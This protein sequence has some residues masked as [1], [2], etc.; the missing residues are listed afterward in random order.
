MKH[1]G[2]LQRNGQVR[3]FDVLGRG[4]QAIRLVRS[5]TKPGSLYYTD[6]WHAQGSIIAILTE[7]VSPPRIFT[8]G[9]FFAANHKF[10][11]ISKYPNFI[12][13]LEK[14]AN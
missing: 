7:G 5:N 1:T 4:N 6:D 2:I 3:V 8:S 13:S 10:E 9:Y 12:L 11:N 14:F